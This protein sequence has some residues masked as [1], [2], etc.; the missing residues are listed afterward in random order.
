M[1]N[2]SKGA[3]FDLDGTIY[4]GDSL[5]PGAKQ[6]ISWLKDHGFSVVFISNKPLE[7]TLTYANKLSRLGIPTKPSDIINSTKALIY[8]LRKNMPKAVL[9]P[10]GEEPLL[11]ELSQSFKLSED[12]QEIDIVIA[13]FDR[14]FNY[15]K[16]EIGFQALKNG[17][18]FF[19]TNADPTCPIPGGEIPD[20]GA[21]IGALEGC[22]NKKVEFVAG[23]PSNLIINL[24]LKMVKAKPEKCLLVGDRLS[25]DI[26]MG[27]ESKIQTILVLSGVTS[28]ADI[29]ESSIKPDYVIDN[30]TFLPQ[31]IENKL[32]KSL[33]FT[34]D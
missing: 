10:I 11:N 29:A 1:N 34:T 15:Q 26:R 27:K 33:L 9:F 14:H 4:T 23:K 8:Y 18:R 20:A 6:A 7:S 13:S 16:L 24:S 2:S 12:P 30:L 32:S 5:L 19:A 31:L 21:V 25:T 22:S 3:I 17:A 28:Q